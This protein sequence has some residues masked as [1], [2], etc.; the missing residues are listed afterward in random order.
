MSNRSKTLLLILVDTLLLILCLT[1]VIYLRKSGEPSHFYIIRH[2]K[3]FSFIF[4]FW[5][6]NYFIEGLYTLKTYNPA[7]LT[8]S[9]LRST[10]FSVFVSVIVIYLS[11]YASGSI[12]PK[13]NLLLVAMLSLPL[14][15]G[16]R[17]FFFNFFSRDVRLRNTLLIGSQE[18]INLVNSEI[19]HKPHLGYKIFSTCNSEQAQDLSIGSEVALVAIERR[20]TKDVDL[21]N[22][23]FSLLG[24][25]VEVIDLAKFAEKISGKIP[26]QAI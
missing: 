1:V 20:M 6:L 25:G 12:T 10:V 9:L 18:T 2:Y 11:N 26:I 23:I 16:W 15:Y 8:I 19:N 3:L 4:P 5:L 13:T 21:Y 17:Q 7:N 22:R 24:S 14:L